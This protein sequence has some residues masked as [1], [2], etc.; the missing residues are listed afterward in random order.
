MYQE[1]GVSLTHRDIIML[2]KKYKTIFYFTL[3]E[4]SSRKINLYLL[5]FVKAYAKN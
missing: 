4:K 2:K 5:H 3:L 1:A